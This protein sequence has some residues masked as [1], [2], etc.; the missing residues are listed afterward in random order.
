MCG[1]RP[2]YR[3]M[4]FCVRIPAWDPVGAAGSKDITTL[5]EWSEGNQ[6]AL[7]ELT[8]LVYD[9]LRLLAARALRHERPGHTLQ[10]TALVHEAYL[11]LIDQRRVRWQDREHFFAVA[12]QMIRRIL[13]NHARGAIRLSGAGWAPL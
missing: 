1:C 5:L 10:S 3:P 2:C 6:D 7:C 4:D 13:V 12:A 8:P 11:K 9:Q